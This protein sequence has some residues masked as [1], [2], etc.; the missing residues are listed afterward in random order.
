ML[1]V[2][3]GVAKT[4]PALLAA[5]YA[6]RLWVY[7][8]ARERADDVVKGARLLKHFSKALEVSLISNPNGPGGASIE[9]VNSH[10]SSIL[11]TDT[12]SKRFAEVADTY[13]RWKAS[14]YFMVDESNRQD[15]ADR[16]AALSQ[17]QTDCERVMSLIRN[18]GAKELSRQNFSSL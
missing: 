14:E 9:A 1:A 18:T 15:I 5:Y 10:L 6:Y 8:T 13:Y 16:R 7:K 4:L 17:C 11:I 2:V 3:D 12:L